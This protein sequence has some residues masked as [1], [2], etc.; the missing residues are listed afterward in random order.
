MSSPRS[1]SRSRSRSRSTARSAAASYS[2]CSRA[3]RAFSTSL[4][5]TVLTRRGPRARGADASNERAGCSEESNSTEFANISSAARRRTLQTLL[6]RSLI[7]SLRLA[8]MNQS[9]RSCAA[10]RIAGL[11][12]VSRRRAL[13]ST[14]RSLAASTMLPKCLLRARVAASSL[15]CASDGGRFENIA[16]DDQPGL[17]FE[18]GH[19]RFGG[20]KSGSLQGSGMASRGRPR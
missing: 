4:A 12:Q 1:C 9:I 6:P 17:G 14:L 11:L 2:R 3:T 8:M 7:N 16:I 19:G 5:A 13:R 20:W 10:S 15:R 18:L